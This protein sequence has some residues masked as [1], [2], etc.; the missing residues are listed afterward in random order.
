M[1]T[2]SRRCISKRG[3]YEAVAWHFS[4]RLGRYIDRN[5]PSAWWE[6]E[7]FFR[8]NDFHFLPVIEHML[9]EARI[10]PT[11][12][13]S[14]GD[15]L[16]ELLKGKVI[17]EIGCRYGTFLQL[18]RNYGAKVYATTGEKYYEEAAKRLGKNHVFLSDATNAHQHL[19]ALKPDIVLNFNLFL[20]NRWNKSNKNRPPPPR[21]LLSKLTEIG[22]PKTR[23]YVMPAVE[24]RGPILSRKQF[25]RHPRVTR[26]NTST[27]F[28][29]HYKIPATEEKRWNLHSY[30][31]NARN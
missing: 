20:K 31:F 9:T 16:R 3:L 12:T 2:R 26:F 25:R 17:I 23:F 13:K 27:K 30:V 5:G 28:T 4:D 1:A 22:T 8:Q 11:P 15:C 21:V 6:H 19:K 10:T 14:V 7:R 18:L 24:N 29:P